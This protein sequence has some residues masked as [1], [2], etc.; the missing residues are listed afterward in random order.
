MHPNHNDGQTTAGGSDSSHDIARGR[1][2]K[3]PRRNRSRTGEGSVVVSF[4]VGSSEADILSRHRSEM[5][6]IIEDALLKMKEAE[7]KKLWQ[8]VG[9]ELENDPY[10][11][12]V[13]WANAAGTDA[14]RSWLD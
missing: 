8:L 1:S 2:A 3:N 9:E 14:A 7:Q 10:D 5:Q 4:R 6:K 11:W 12:E 13:E